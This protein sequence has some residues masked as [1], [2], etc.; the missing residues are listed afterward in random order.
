MNLIVEDIGKVV[1]AMRAQGSDVPYYMY[2]HKLE[3]NQRLIA[4]GKA[5]IPKYPL[6]VLILDTAEQHEGSVIRYNLNIGILEY[7]KAN[8]NAE[9]RYENVFKP[10]LIPLY[11]KFLQCLPAGKF[12]WE[13]QE[14]VHTK[15]DRPFYGVT[16]LNRNA[17]SIFSDPLDCVEIQNLKI[18]RTI[19]C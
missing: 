2:G 8:Y 10:T 11:E 19:K 1:Q 17:R 4:K 13:E 3:I 12:F 6:V 16:E 15:I 5:N 9:E 14:P 18:S 7:T